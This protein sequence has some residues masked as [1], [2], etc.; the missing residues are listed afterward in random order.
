M[1]LFKKT[2]LA[3]TITSL[4]IVSNV[5][6]DPHPN[7]EKNS[8]D[9]TI[10][11]TAAQDE[12]L[13]SKQSLDS[14]DI[15]NTPS[16][17]GNLT[18]YLKDNPN[19]R[20][21]DSD[22]SGFTGGEIKPTS[23]SINGADTNQTAY[24]IDGINVNN[25][26]D[27]SGELFDGSM[28]VNPNQSSEQAYFFDANMLSGVTVYSSDVPAKLGGFTGGAVSA[29]TRQYSG[30]NRV[31]LRYRT[32]QSDWSSMQVDDNAKNIVDKATPNG[33]DAEYQPEYKKNFF[34][35]MAEQEI[36]D[37]IGMVVGFSRRESDIQQS[38]KINPEGDIDKQAHT[39]LSDNFLA[40][41]NW[42]PTVDHSLEW[43]LRLSDYQEGKYYA[44]NINGNVTDSHLAYGSTLRWNQYLGNGTLTATAA[45]DKFT[46]ERDSSSNDAVVTIDLDTNANYEQGGYGNS[47]MT[48]E[49]TNLMLDYVFDSFSLADTNHVFSL[50]TSYRKT[51]YKF[52]R[53]NN[54]TQ[55]TI[56]TMGGWEMMNETKTVRKGT[57]GTQYQDYAF[58]AEDVIQ[59]NNVTIRPGV[60]VDHDDY[61]ENTNVAP[62]FVTH[63]QALQ[64][65]RLNF[66][67]NRYYGRSFASMKLAG[68]VLKLNDDQTRR[69]ETIDSLE[70]PYADELSVGVNQNIGNFMLTAQYVLRDNQQRITVDR[71]KIAGENVDSYSNGSNYKVDVYTLQVS[72]MTPWVVG[73]TQWNATLG[74]DWLQTDRAA[75]NKGTD[76]N[77][78]VY[79]DG[80]LMSRS[81]MEQA[82][83]SSEEEWIV[84]LGSDMSIPAID[85]VWSNKVYI[86]APVQGYDYITDAPDGTEMH[87]SYDFGTHTQWDTRMRWQPNLVGTHNAY[88][89]LDVLNVL[90]KVRK[91]ATMGTSSGD[92]GIY[93]PGREFWLE[94]GYEF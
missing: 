15:K 68:E 67:L 79:L 87:T 33:S 37:D 91:K 41:F 7:S 8:S 25:D 82:V 77:Q 66:G 46:D 61:L 48:Q 35:I 88:V 17:N 54:V 65:T 11:I 94:L 86:K 2:I 39:R 5:Y 21:A 47:Q 30:E 92:Y 3:T 89:Q 59:W 31:K 56:M 38:R 49:N 93:S 53:D 60:R 23:V 14:E 70:T 20:F 16:S 6:A 76:P 52:N 69:Y 84:R 58:Y 40:N 74:A 24:L 29:E 22:Q 62:R 75:L 80:K 43:G 71:E 72:N 13:S 27:P 73:P 10:T 81:Q 19:V 28:S 64:D 63:W 32:T 50:G 45:Y 78:A 90:N 55:Q 26:I 51:K 85:V 34:S 4:C 83:N 42:T 57:I 18:D 36:T 12:D 1:C 44:D 9:L